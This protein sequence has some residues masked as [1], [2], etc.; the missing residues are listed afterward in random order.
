MVVLYSWVGHADLQSFLVQLPEGKLKASVQTLIPSGREVREG[1]IP[2]P[3]ETAIH[4]RSYDKVILLWS[5]A[6]TACVEAYAGFLGKRCSIELVPIS[7]PID[8]GE[9][10]TAAERVLGASAGMSQIHRHI[11]LS[12]GTPAMAAVWL[13]LGKTKYPAEFLQAYKGKV[14]ETNIPFD[15]KVD[16]ITKLIKD[17]D[18]ELGELPNKMLADASG[19]EEII[20]TS[21]ALRVAVNMAKRASLHEVNVLITGESGTG[22][23]LFARAIHKASCRSSGPFFAVNCGAISESLLDSE[24]FGYVKGAFTDAKIDKKGFFEQADGGTL[25]LDEIGECTPEMQ[26]KLLRVL[27]PPEGKPFTCREFLPVG[28]TK[29]KHTDVRIIAATNRELGQ[30][31]KSTAFRADLFYRLAAVSICLPPLRERTGDIRL[32]AEHLLDKIN[33][34]LATNPYYSPKHFAEN[35]LLAMERQ[36]W[37]GNVRELLNTI[38]QGAVMSSG[39][40]ITADG[41]GLV[42]DHPQTEANAL[43]T[44]SHGLDFDQAVADFKRQLIQSVLAKTGNSKTKAYKLLGFKSYQRLDAMMRSLGMEGFP[45]SK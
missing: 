25:F 21:P 43:S 33:K 36:A 2:G 27:Q 20:G 35:A 39:Q 4:A 10:Y 24:L 16:I 1:V 38:I 14:I 7:N 18:R 5:Y 9:I 44:V 22:K 13:L 17:N 40:D 29:C 26:R 30:D 3:I 6:D 32:L 31:I 15:L 8:Y 34:A 45:A 37:E 41:L 23:E 11:L 28:S 19:F 12:P 42:L